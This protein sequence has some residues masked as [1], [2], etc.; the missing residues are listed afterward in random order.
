MDTV[1]AEVR[2]PVAVLTLNRPP[3]MNAI[4]R[5]L[6]ACLAGAVGAAVDN[7]DVRALVIAGAG[8]AFSAGA[9]LDEI[10]A[11]PDAHAFRAFITRM[12][13]VYQVI[14]D[15]QKPS[16]AALHGIAFGG[17]LELALACDLRVA[18]PGTRLG[19]PEMK[20]GV[21]PGAGG[22]QRLPRLVPAGLAKQMILTG[23]PITGERAHAVGLVNE[24]AE[25]GEALAAAVALA[26]QLAAGAPLALAAGKRLVD[27][28]AGMD[29]AAAISYGAESVSMLFGTADQT[30]GLAAFHARR[31]P[32]FTG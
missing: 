7:R 17:G 6:L 25:P 16:V 21:L 29:L 28:G 14:A 15:C 4:N 27:R 1:Q 12:T 11:L 13:E 31:P 24:L 22:T 19:V 26:G 8:R 5:D 10:G 32:T 9:D 18:E 23:E 3:R 30:E 2:G 20:L